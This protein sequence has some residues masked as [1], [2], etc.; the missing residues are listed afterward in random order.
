MRNEVTPTAGPDKSPDSN[1]SHVSTMKGPYSLHTAS[2][3]NLRR[4]EKGIAL[5]EDEGF[6]SYWTH[7]DLGE[8]GKWF[9]LLVGCFMTSDKAKEFRQRYGMTEGLI[10]KT[11]Y[12]VQIAEQSSGEV[13]SY[14]NPTLKKMGGAPYFVRSPETESRLLIGAFTTRKAAGESARRL[15]ETGI[16]CR[17]VLR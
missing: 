1:P 10:S 11:P 9:R 7:V 15:K 8:R 4:L 5:L 16:D 12:A 3:R 14:D 2:F 17:V 6:S 13:L